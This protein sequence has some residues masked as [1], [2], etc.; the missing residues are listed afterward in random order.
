MEL[1]SLTANTTVTDIQWQAY[2]VGFVL[3][4]LCLF[5]IFGNILIITAIIYDKNLHTSKY[6][7]IASLAF[8]DLLVGLIAMPFAFIF[9]MTDDEYWLFP[10][11][12]GFFCG[13]WH[14][15]DIFSSTASIF[16]LS[17]IG[18]DR[19]VSVT[20]PI[21]YPNSF[22]CKRWY[23][24]L[25]FSWLCSAAISFP[26]VIH[27]GTERERERARLLPMNETKSSSSSATA[28]MFKECDFPNNPYY[29]LFVSIASF[30]L[31]LMVMIYVYIQ[32]YLVARNQIK[33][34][35]AGY[36]HHTLDQSSRSFLPKF[37]LRDNSTETTTLESNSSTCSK[38][39]RKPSFQL[40][41]L[42]IH[43]GTYQNPSLEPL[44][45]Q[46]P[47]EHRRKKEILSWKKL[48]R[49][50]KAGKFVGMVMGVFVFCWLPYFVYFI[51]SGVF[52]IRLK[53]EQNHELLFKVLSWL[54][55]TNSA[56]D[57]LIYISTSKELRMTFSK[58]CCKS[59]FR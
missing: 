9:E 13:F 57:I 56:L 34:L 46:N 25:S 58:L 43:H 20:K 48:S 33:A 4:S 23:W 17:A 54:G 35:R 22:I 59:C 16:G 31:P 11:H 40:I 2:P 14:S 47:D 19:Y 7:Y 12:L 3:A 10:K 55:Y 41:T 52:A 36:K 24:I 38:T 18:I 26:A 53:D 6:Y 51:L 21:E 15:M 39:T 8:A 50:Q 29:V 37:A 49:A 1:F 27:F 28:L 32:V 45:G 42:R 5:T 30:Y 44:N